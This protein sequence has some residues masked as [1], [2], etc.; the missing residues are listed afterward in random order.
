[1]SILFCAYKWRKRRNNANGDYAEDPPRQL[2]RPWT[3]VT[4][5]SWPGRR[6]QTDS[7]IMDEMMRAAYDAESGTQNYPP[8][9][10]NENG[11]IDEKK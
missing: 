3:M 4:G 11:Y 10:L 6:K 1:M 5:L 7:K 9:V 8:G 2:P